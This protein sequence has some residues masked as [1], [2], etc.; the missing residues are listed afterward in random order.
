MGI[1]NNKY[2]SDNLCYFILSALSFIVAS[3]WNLAAQKYFSYPDTSWQNIIKYALLITA[4]SVL[5]ATCIA[6]LCHHAKKH[7]ER[8][9]WN[10]HKTKITE[11]E[12]DKRKQV[13]L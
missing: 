3:S 11:N 1:D 13:E 8:I 5:V 6:R 12:L 2:L 4:I 7:E 10:R 9:V